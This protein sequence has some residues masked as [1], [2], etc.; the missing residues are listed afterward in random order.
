MA[1]ATLERKMSFA[2]VNGLEKLGLLSHF[3][4]E[5][6]NDEVRVLEHEGSFLRQHPAIAKFLESKNAITSAD[7]EQVVVEVLATW[8]VILTQ[9]PLQI[10][11]F[12]LRVVEQMHPHLCN[13]PKHHRLTLHDLFPFLVATIAV[14]QQ[15]KSIDEI[16]WHSHV[17]T[18]LLIAFTIVNEVEQPIK[19]K[20]WEPWYQSS[21]DSF[22]SLVI[23]AQNAAEFVEENRTLLDMVRTF[24]FRSYDMPD[25]RTW[26]S[27]G[28]DTTTP[29]STS[30]MVE[31]NLIDSYMT[32]IDN[33][34]ADTILEIKISRK[35]GV[36][37]PIEWSK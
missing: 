37:E 24:D 30:P 31:R 17:R 2:D 8:P 33:V 21:A 35:L 11:Q 20:P 9:R 5:R 10:Q 19:S 22:Q 23:F 16:D 27:K 32:G 34:W 7:A 6:N 18:L 15:K 3:Y 29:F 13:L 12:L 4:T 14:T 25:L 28:K 36:P 1:P 26:P